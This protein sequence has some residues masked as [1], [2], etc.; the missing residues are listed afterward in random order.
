MTDVFK[1]GVTVSLINHATFGLAQLARDFSRTDVEAKRLEAT[2]RSIKTLTLA[3]GALVGAG[4][5]GIKALET[6][7]EAAKKYTQ[8]FAGFKAIGLGDAINADANKFAQGTRV[9][10]ASATD[11]IKIMADLHTVTGNYDYAKK[12]TPL[13][14]RM[15][16]ANKAIY[17]DDVNFNSKQAGDLER[18]IEQ[19]G[20]F[21]TPEEMML[22]ANYMQ[23]VISGTRG[24][25][26]PSQYLAY[27][28]TGGV[29]ASLQGNDEFYYQM[30]PLIQEMGGSRVGTGIMSAYQNLGQGRTTKRAVDELARLGL[31]TGPKHDFSKLSADQAAE[32]FGSKDMDPEVR[33]HFVELSKSG[34]LVQ[35]R[36]GAIAG[37]DMVARNP[38]EFLQKILLPA[39]KAHG[40]VTDDAIINEIGTLFTNRTAAAIYTRLFQQQDK[41]AKNIG[42]NRGALGIDDLQ[43]EADNTP[44]G[45]EI[46]AEAAWENLRIQLGL[47]IIPLVVPMIGKLA[48]ALESLA[49]FANKNPNFTTALM[50][51]AVAL[52]ALATVGGS[53]LLARAG[54][55]AAITFLGLLA[56]AGGAAT[57]AA[58]AGS[59]LGVGGGLGI[60]AG[61]AAALPLA[62]SGDVA[63]GSGLKPGQLSTGARLSLWSKKN[64][65]FD[66]NFGANDAE[67]NNS[68]NRPSGSIDD[69]MNRVHQS[70]K[71]LGDRIEGMSVTLNGRVV[72]S[73]MS[74]SIADT[75]NKPLSG[76][77]AFD[78]RMSYPPPV[79]AAP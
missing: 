54:W 55:D 74:D 64:L 61:L 34:Q 68:Q 42:V 35:M 62:L 2:F 28:K 32:I 16:Y 17:G 10:G 36:P 1:I 7:Y 12:L 79:G 45:Q 41:I 33:K 60:G 37:G 11:L 67:L 25:V 24:R 58:G 56:R 43:K 70:I 38:M 39:L 21:R 20:G 71:E 52:T 66:V 48:D 50:G 19:R 40:F 65:G 78:S 75:L 29:A 72:G 59:A 5:L 77:G 3:G 47:K 30:E 13:I 31:I 69:A 6:T 18:V 51:T 15:E 26:M 22:Q 14:A 9:M 27:Q 46:R 8:A 53:L 44:Q 23:H 4:A 73:V 63:Q 57:G 49:L 76:G